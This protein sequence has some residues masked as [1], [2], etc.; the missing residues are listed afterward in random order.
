MRYT[1]LLSPEAIEDLRSLRAHIRAEVVDAME[2]HLRHQPSAISRTRIK[3]LE[4]E[5]S[6]EYRLR[7]GDTRV[8]YDVVGEEVWII[9]VVP[10]AGAEAWLRKVGK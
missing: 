5:G 9:A 8:F 4:G 2:V 7:V 1:I 10:R 3:R 6:P